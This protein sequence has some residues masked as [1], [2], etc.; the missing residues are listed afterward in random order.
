ML[1]GLPFSIPA[2]EKGKEMSVGRFIFFFFFPGEGKGEWT[3]VMNAAPC[4]HR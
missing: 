3:G 4:S 2:K 1:E